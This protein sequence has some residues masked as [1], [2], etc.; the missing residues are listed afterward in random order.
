[1]VRQGYSLQFARRPPRFHGVLATTVRSEDTQVLRAEVMNLLG[2]GAI[3][4]KHI[5]RH[6]LVLIVPLWK[7][8]T[9]VSELFQLLKAAPWP[10][11][12]R[13]DLLSQANG[14]IWHPRPELWAPACVSARREPFVLPE[15][16][17]NRRL[18][19]L[20]W[21]IFSDW[22]QDRD[23]D[24]VTSNVSVVLSFLKGMLDKQH[25][26]STIKVYTAAIA[27]FHVPISSLSVGRASTVITFV[28]G[29][30]IINLH[31][32]LVILQTL[33]S[34]ATYNWEIHKAINLEESNRQRKC[35]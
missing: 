8:Q 12:L 9:W 35:P 3:E 11:P 17:L 29:A 30:R 27:A 16:V 28:Q 7:N 33:L 15:R 21:S 34:K 2:K 5:Q 22:C 20:K 25:S 32:H 19:F 13:R 1:M 18:Y 4:I 31:L 6:K 10:I 24:P 26:S 23:L 14:T